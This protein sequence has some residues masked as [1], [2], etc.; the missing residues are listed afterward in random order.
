M[1]NTSFDLSGKID[2]ETVSVLR[3]IKDVAD[4]LKIPFFVVGAAARDIILRYCCNVTPHRATMDIDIAVEVENWT[5][6][7]N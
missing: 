5:Q 6:F 7:V 1:K 3:A 4:S 2:A